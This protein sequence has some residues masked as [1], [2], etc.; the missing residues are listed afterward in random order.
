MRRHPSYTYLRS[1]KKW[2]R[3]NDERQNKACQRSKKRQS[4]SLLLVRLSNKILGKMG[5]GEMRLGEML[6]NRTKWTNWRLTSFNFVSLNLFA[7]WRDIVVTGRI[8]WNRQFSAT[9][10]K[11]LTP[12]IGRPSS[13]RRRSRY[14]A[15]W[16]TTID[17]LRACTTDWQPLRVGLC[18]Q[19]RTLPDWLTNSW[20][21]A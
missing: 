4:K 18:I 15:D 3:K 1:A 20:L 5:L 10:S 14:V 8:K 6:P 11:R 16:P 2:Y 7:S 12:Q 9:W 19:N 13:N 21:S 17:K